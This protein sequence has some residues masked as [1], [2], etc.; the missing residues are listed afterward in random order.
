MPMPQVLSSMLAG[1][2]ACSLAGACAAQA[3]APTT[4]PKTVQDAVRATL[5]GLNGVLFERCRQVDAAAADRYALSQRQLGARVDEV[6][7]GM[8]AA[9]GATLARPVP[10]VL[11][12]LQPMMETLAAQDRAPTPA[13]CQRRLAETDGMSGPALKALVLELVL[14]QD[15]AIDELKQGM[16]R[17]LP[18]AAPR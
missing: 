12:A 13:Q 3:S 16:D 4:T 11:L 18:E 7:A 5:T 17:V 8:A 2:L 10:A 9:H 6:F 1:L 15:R 14:S